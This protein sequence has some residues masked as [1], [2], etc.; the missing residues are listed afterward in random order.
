MRL[1]RVPGLAVALAV[2]AAAFANGLKPPP[3]KTV[4]AWAAEK[5]IVAAESGSSFPGRWSNERAPYL[6]EIMDVLSLSHPA[7]EVTFKKSSQVA[8]TEAGLNLIGQIIDE[9]PA[10]ILIVLPS[11]DDGKRYVKT[12]LQP[13]IDETPSLKAKVREQKSRDEDGST[14]SF[15]KFRG[16][17]LQVTGANSSKGLQMISVRVLIR[18]E[19][20]E[21][22]QDVDNRGD[23][24]DLAHARVAVWSGR[25]KEFNCS[26]P[27][28]KGMCRVSDRYELSDQRRYHVPCP[29]CGHEQVLEWK[30]MAVDEKA[31]DTA[32]YVCAANGCV[33][34]HHAKAEMLR[35]GRWV[36][37]FPNENRQPG[38]HINALYSPFVSWADLAREW[39]EAKGKPQKEKVF[40]QQKLGEEYEE[41][42]EAPDSVKLLARKEAFRFG[43][44]PAGVLLLTM[45]VDVQEKRLE[46][47]VWGWGI[48]KSTW[49][50]DKGI[51]DGDTTVPATWRELDAIVDRRYPDLLGNAWPIDRVA[52]DSGYNTQA[53]Y[54]WCRG[55][56]KVLA[57]KGMPG[58]L[59]P[60][61]GTPS[62]QEVNWQGKKWK[63]GIR[64]WPV[65]TWTL[66]SEF[67]AN[68]RKTIDGPDADG[69][70]AP[71]YVHVGEDV[72]EAY[73][74]QLT[75]ESLQSR[76]T[77]AGRIVR[78]WVVQAGQRNEGL[79]T[80]IYAG[81]AAA[82]LG[83]DLWSRTKWAELAAHR[84][85]PRET[86]QRDLEAL[87]GTP[88]KAASPVS[89]HVAAADKAEAQATPQT[90]ED[91]AKALLGL[92]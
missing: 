30:Q 80:R 11:I 67:Y 66:K 69:N 46:W 1:S 15:K 92:T 74:K 88:A 2:A 53:V 4:S 40:T 8:G 41:K 43:T 14:T 13:T 65:G 44:L 32:H 25:E 60:A 16:G 84:N 76:Q 62:L 77:R 49:L 90:D 79:D 83:V 63:R 81:A 18:E 61:I 37:R 27:G 57:I 10:P 59:A 5:R 73:L 87:W 34:E 36:A 6:V 22:P 3:V 21:W 52:V 39:L 55:K 89:G 23:P 26:T 20:S 85:V 7:R 54:A 31:P 9:T 29:Q 17:F 24:M 56:P 19:I 12:K 91:R 75:A 28:L 51:I 71:G 35:R 64:L 48:G 47:A 68:L 72:D 58:H 42:G 50:V 38:F 78:E 70:F 45:G 33:I 86:V 82:H